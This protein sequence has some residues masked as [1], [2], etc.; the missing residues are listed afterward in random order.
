MILER[1]G[2]AFVQ[3]MRG[4]AQSCLHRTLEEEPRKMLPNYQMW[5]PTSLGQVGLDSV[6][7]LRWDIQ[8]E[9]Q[10]EWKNGG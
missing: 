5:F 1:A 7:S 10:M 3:V 4:L 6:Q 9:F 2:Q 8:H